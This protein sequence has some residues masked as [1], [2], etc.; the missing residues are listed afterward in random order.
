MKVI[1]SSSV[2]IQRRNGVSSA[3]YSSLEGSDRIA[4]KSFQ[5]W[6]NK[7][8]SAQLVTDGLYGP[9]SKA[10]Y[11]K[12]GAEWGKAQQSGAPKKDTPPPATDKPAAEQKTKDFVVTTTKT[13]LM[14]KIKAL[15][16]PAKIGIGVGLA[17]ILGVIIW[18]LTPSKKG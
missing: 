4:V 7:V 3:K 6:A 14:D 15:P 16:M 9:K 11:K 12:W 18:K 5:E 2:I 8:Y 17:A 1:T 13:G 10:A